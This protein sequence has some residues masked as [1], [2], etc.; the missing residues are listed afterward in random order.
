MIDRMVQIVLVIASLLLFVTCAAAQSTSIDTKLAAQYFA[1]LKQTSERDGGKT[2]GLPLYG[3]MILVDPRSRDVV[4]N[5]ADRENKLVSR[6]GV[7]VG[8]LPNEICRRSSNCS[9]RLMA[10]SGCRWSG[11]HWSAHYAK[12]TSAKSRD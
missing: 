1:Q 5:Q 10:A 3:P 11:E 8:T 7:F 2:W 6:D 4:A 12:P 9:T